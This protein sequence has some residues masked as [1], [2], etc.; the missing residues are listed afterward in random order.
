MHESSG[1]TACTDCST[2]PHS[3][4][5]SLE[6]HPATGHH[7]SNATAI[8][9]QPSICYIIHLCDIWHSYLDPC[10]KE[11]RVQL[12]R[13]QMW[14]ASLASFCAASWCTWPVTQHACMHAM[15]PALVLYV[16]STQSHQHLPLLHSATGASASSSWA[17][18]YLAATTLAS[19]G[20]VL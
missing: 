7:L 2:T 13:R 10:L 11:T 8:Q 18:P 14:L 5:P 20:Q 16:Q 1:D 9:P 4:T 19:V 6:P 12:R 15:L 17:N 3:L